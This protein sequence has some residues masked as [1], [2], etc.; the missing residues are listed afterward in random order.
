MSIRGKSIN[1]LLSQQKAE[2][3]EV[4][5]HRAISIIQDCELFGYDINSMPELTPEDVIKKQQAIDEGNIIPEVLLNAMKNGQ[6]WYKIRYNGELEKMANAEL[7]EAIGRFLQYLASALQIKPELTHAINDY[8][9]IEMVKNVSN[10]TNSNIIKSK[11]E[12]KMIL[13]QLQEAQ[14]QA[15]AQQ[16]MMQ[17]GAM[18]KDMATGTKLV[19]G[20]AR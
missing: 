19:V 5:L 1:G 7:Y 14:A 13:E 8:E 11:T 17:Q 6:R 2:C 16:M 18:L 10:L 15:Q 20:R 9:F 4:L 12:Y 3:I